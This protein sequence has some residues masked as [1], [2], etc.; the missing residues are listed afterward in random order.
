MQQAIHVFFT[1]AGGDQFIYSIVAF[2]LAISIIYALI[3]NIMD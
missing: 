2:A 1:L 3:D